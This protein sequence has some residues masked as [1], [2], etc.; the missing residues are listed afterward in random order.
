MMAVRGIQILEA[1]GRSGSDKA[2]A[3]GLRW[4]FHVRLRIH[5][6]IHPSNLLAYRYS[7]RQT[8]KRPTPNADGAQQSAGGQMQEAGHYS[9]SAP[10]LRQIS[11]AL[12]SLLLA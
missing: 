1:G 3:W 2:W 4:L 12:C 5:P 6:P 7:Q 9:G 8:A 10:S 11:S